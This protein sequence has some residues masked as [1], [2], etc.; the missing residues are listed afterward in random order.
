[1]NPIIFEA[2]TTPIDWHLKMQI[3]SATPQKLEQIATFVRS[4]QPFKAVILEAMAACKRADLPTHFLV[5]IHGCSN[6]E[7]ASS[8]H[9]FLGVYGTTFDLREWS[10]PRLQAAVSELHATENAGLPDSLFEPLEVCHDR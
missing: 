9:V 4:G 7:E 2:R 3:Q 5:E 8:V 1:M 6:L 10:P